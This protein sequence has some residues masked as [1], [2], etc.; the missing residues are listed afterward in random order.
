MTN[1][2]ASYILAEREGG[3]EPSRF[4]KEVCEALKSLK[5]YA[6]T[7]EMCGD[8]LLSSRCGGGVRTLAGDFL[9]GH[10]ARYF[11]LY[12]SAYFCIFMP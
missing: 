5:R 11:A 10:L 9:T 1:H 8:F 7:F 12:F 6:N 4:K 3:N 2:H